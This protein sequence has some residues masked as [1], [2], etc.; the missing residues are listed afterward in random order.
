MR[1]VGTGLGLAIVH[2]LV[3]RLGGRVEAGHAPEGGAR[4]TVG[5]PLAG[6]TPG[7]PRAHPDGGTPSPTS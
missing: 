1:Q 4:F 2:R 7:A 6:P 3:T 5:L